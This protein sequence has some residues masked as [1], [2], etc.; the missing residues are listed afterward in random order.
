MYSMNKHLDR[1]YVDQFKLQ[2]LAWQR[3]DVHFNLKVF[4]AFQILLCKHNERSS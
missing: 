3:A 1:F 4:L 2:T